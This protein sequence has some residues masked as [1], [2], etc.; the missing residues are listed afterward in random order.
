MAKSI[1]AQWRSTS[2]R[3]CVFASGQQVFAWKLRD[4]LIAL[5]VKNDQA[6]APLPARP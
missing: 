6:P 1:V 2:G 5:R 3:S 4:E